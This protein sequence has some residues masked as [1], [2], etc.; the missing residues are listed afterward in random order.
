MSSQLDRVDQDLRTMTDQYNADQLKSRQD[1]MNASQNKLAAISG[2][3]QPASNGKKLVT[4]IIL[5]VIPALVLSFFVWNWGNQQNVSLQ[6]ELQ[7]VK[8]LN[9]ELENRQAELKEILNQQR[10]VS[11]SQTLRFESNLQ[12]TTDELREIGQKQEEIVAGHEE[13][14]RL[15]QRQVRVLRQQLN[16]RLDSQKVVN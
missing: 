11:A 14:I 10:S 15:L 7:E 8:Q 5:A 13:K 4:Q 1:L 12:S 6:K 2:E 3:S 16:A 9:T